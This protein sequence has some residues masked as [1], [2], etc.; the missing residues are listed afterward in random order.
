LS[1]LKGLSYHDSPVPCMYF[2]I[3]SRL[4]IEKGESDFQIMVFTVF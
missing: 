1:P 3:I 4:K 2:S